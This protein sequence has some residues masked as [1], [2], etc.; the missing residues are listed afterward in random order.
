MILFK[1][2]GHAIS[3]G[4]GIDPVL[5]LIAEQ[6]KA[7]KKIVIVHGGGPAINREL[8][9]HGVNGEMIG[10]LRKTTPEVFEIVQRTLCGEVQRKLVNQLIALGID[11]VGMTAGDGNLTRAKISRPDLGL[12]GEVD[13]TNP[14]FLIALMELGVTP[15]ISPVSITSDGQAV[16][17]NADIVAGA[18][19]GA[20]NAESVL[21]STDVAGIY[22]NW[23][24]KDSLIASIS[25]DELTEI[26][27]TFE[28][29]MIPKAESA[30]N[31]IKSGAK[32][33]QIFDGR[34]VSQ[35]ELALQG[36]SGTLVLP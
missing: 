21:F 15:V 14:K 10:G 24:D 7:G 17:M 1:Y 33:A 12:V 19:G 20:L 3:E 23:P 32:K 26:S 4:Q 29:G 2:G 22:R 9:V 30:I 13:S 36:K 16:N 34:E 6:I 35:V 18:V 25:V 27:K 28:G 5:I 8:E 11:A 31:A